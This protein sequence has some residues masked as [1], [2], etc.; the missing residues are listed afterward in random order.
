MLTHN[1]I[2][3]IVLDKHVRI[4]KDFKNRCKVVAFRFIAKRNKHALKHTINLQIQFH[5]KMLVD[6]I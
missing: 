1:Y 4:I 6:A 5:M 3:I 2:Q